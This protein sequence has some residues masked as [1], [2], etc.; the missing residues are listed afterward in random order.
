MN[1]VGGQEASSISRAVQ[2]R[3]AVICRRTPALRMGLLRGVW[4]GDPVGYFG[5][6]LPSGACKKI[7]PRLLAQ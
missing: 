7:G 1:V 3:H 5:Y 6:Q 2:A 4:S